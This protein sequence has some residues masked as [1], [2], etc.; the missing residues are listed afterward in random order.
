MNGVSQPATKTYFENMLR[1]INLEGLKTAMPCQYFI[2]LS[3]LDCAKC[4]NL[5]SRETNFAMKLLL[6]HQVTGVRLGA[7]HCHIPSSTATG[8]RK[9]DTVKNMCEQLAMVDTLPRWVIGGVSQRRDAWIQKFASRRGVAQPAY[10]G[11][12]T[13]EQWRSWLKKK[14]KCM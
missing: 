6:R 9:E 12:Y 3:V 4:D 7:L 1:D 11:E 14:R 10:S 2:T 8:K 5:C 13:T